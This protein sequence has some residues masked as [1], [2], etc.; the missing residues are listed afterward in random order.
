MWGVGA[1]RAPPRGGAGGAALSAML[2]VA[3]GVTAEGDTATA[4]LCLP[5][6][7]RHGHSENPPALRPS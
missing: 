4:D 2:G 1:R 3:P 6:V 5:S 7:C